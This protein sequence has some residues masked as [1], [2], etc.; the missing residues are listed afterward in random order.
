MHHQPDALHPRGAGRSA[1]G[2]HPAHRNTGKPRDIAVFLPICPVLC[3]GDYW[4]MQEHRQRCEELGGAGFLRLARLIRARSSAA[5]L[6]DCAELPDNVVTGEALITFTVGRHR[7]ETR[8]LYHWDYPVQ[9]RGLPVASFPG[10]TLIGMSAGQ[11]APLI[12]GDGVVGVVQVLAV[13]AQAAHD[14]ALCA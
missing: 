3:V 4:Q 6:V 11:R 5:R 7:P 13:H 10:I 8:R 12:D 2:H 9:G 1:Q 14:W